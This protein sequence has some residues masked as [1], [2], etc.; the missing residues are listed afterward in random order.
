[1]TILTAKRLKQ[2]IRPKHK[3]LAGELPVSLR[4]DFCEDVYKRSKVSGR[5]R[6][7]IDEPRIKEW[8]HWALIT[9]IFPYDAAFSVNH[10]LIPKRVVSE[11]ALSTPE[12]Q[13]LQTILRELSSQYDCQ[14]TN[15]VSKQSVKD[16]YHIHLLT[17]KASRANVK[18]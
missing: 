7:L 5:S 2:T 4:T 1:M 16:H 10:M 11:E 14:M 18:F 9:N 17:F 12:R 8:Q 6:P 3:K 15:F 13:E